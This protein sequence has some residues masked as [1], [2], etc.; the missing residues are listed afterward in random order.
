ME[1]AIQ[2]ETEAAFEEF[3]SVDSNND[4]T[5]EVEMEVEMQEPVWTDKISVMERWIPEF[6]FKAGSKVDA[7]QIPTPFDAF[8]LFFSLAL[9]QD[10]LKWSNAEAKRRDPGFKLITMPELMKV[11]GIQIVMCIKRLKNEAD[12]WSKRRFLETPEIREAMS[13]DG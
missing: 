1:F 2:F 5:E 9:L 13:R 12:H 11:F 3:T 6:K 4:H 8:K 10:I 7:S